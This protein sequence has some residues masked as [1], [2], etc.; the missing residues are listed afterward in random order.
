M[1]RQLIFK[2]LLR[3]SAGAVARGTV[4][5]TF[6]SVAILSLAS[7]IHAY[8]T[9]APKSTLIAK[10]SVVNMR[11]KE[12]T[13]AFQKCDGDKSCLAKPKKAFIDAA[14][15]AGEAKSNV[16]IAE[17]YASIEVSSIGVS[18]FTVSMLALEYTHKRRRRRFILPV[19]GE[20][21]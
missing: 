15:V 21:S 10:T 17:K 12:L 20:N 16:K 3:D 2:Q 7:P 9:E 11:F 19:Q 13:A 18:V 1:V 8:Q 4:A 6:A 14:N 5:F